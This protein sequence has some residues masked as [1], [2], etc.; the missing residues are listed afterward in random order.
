MLVRAMLL[1]SGNP[2]PWRHCQSPHAFPGETT[3]AP[4]LS[5]VREISAVLPYFGV[6]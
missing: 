5:L 3:M 1:L 6:E 4:T 2:V